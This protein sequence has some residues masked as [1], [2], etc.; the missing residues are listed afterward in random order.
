VRK[1]AERSQGAAGEIADL[2]KSSVDVA[3]KAGEMINGIIPDIRKTAELVQEISAASS[4]QNSGSE[5]IN[6]ALMQLDQVV[7]RNASA[8]QEIASTSDG[9]SGQAEELQSAV[10]FF[11]TDETHTRAP[12]IVEPD[13]SADW[14]L[15]RQDDN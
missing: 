5:Q 3:E 13:D 10:A 11:K 4:E 6:Q 8:W 12:A 1:P 14:C 2:S 7:Q 15:I 9:L